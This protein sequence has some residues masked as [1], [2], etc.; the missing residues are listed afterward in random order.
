MISQN[1]EHL[2][3]LIGAPRSGTTL[4]SVILTR[5][6]ELHCPPELWLGLPATE[7][8]RAV[9]QLARLDSD[10]ELGQRALAEAFEERE[11]REMVASFLVD[12]Y[13]RILGRAGSAKMLI[14]K[15]PRYYK[16]GSLLAELLPAAR[17][18]LLARNPLDVAASQKL[19]WKVDLARLARPA[20]I[21]APSFDLFCAP[22][23]MV[24][25]RQELGQRAHWLHYEALV[26]RPAEVMSGVCGFL[27]VP[28]R[29]ELL[30]YAADAEEVEAHRSSS[31]GDREIW[32]HRAING[33]AAGRWRDLL[34]EREARLV[35]GLVGAETFEA[36]GY[37][38]PYPE[39]NRVEER[40]FLRDALLADLT[41]VG[42][43]AGRGSGKAEVA[44][45]RAKLARAVQE[46]EAERQARARWQRQ[47]EQ[48]ES[49]REHARGALAEEAAE[50]E[51][52]RQVGRQAESQRDQFGVELKAELIAKEHWQRVSAAER[53]ARVRERE[54]REAESAEKEHWRQLCSGAELQIELERAAR[55]AEL[56]EKERWQRQ[57]AEAEIQRDAERA[58]REEEAAARERWQRQCSEAEI[59]RDAERA[60]REE[61][62]AARERWQRQCSEAEIQRDAERAAREEEAA[63]KEHWSTI[64]RAAEAQRD[65]YQ[66]DLERLEMLWPWLDPDWVDSAEL[67]RISIVTPS[68]NQ[69]EWIE[70][71]LQSVLH[72]R[73]PNFEHIVV[74]GGS[75]DGT[76]EIVARYPHIRF[77][78]EPDLGQAH[79]INKGILVATGDIVAYLNSDDLYRTGAFET[80][81]KAFTSDPQLMALAGGCDYVDEA[82]ATIG[83]MDARLDRY[84]D[85]LRYWGWESWF[86]LPQQ[87][88][89]WR[90]DLL[91][92]VGLFDV[93]FQFTMD[94]EMWLR[95]AARHPFRIEE[96]T[97]AAFRMQAESK[98]ISRTHLMYLEER[99]AARR[100]WP[101]WWRSSRW[102]LEVT[103]LRH[104]GRK[105]LDVAEHEAL[106]NRHRRHPL[107]LLRLGAAHW[108]L[109][110][111][112]PRWLLTLASAVTAKS[113]IGRLTAR[114]HRGYLHGLWRLHRL[115]G[116]AQ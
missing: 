20:G 67:P 28:Y 99:R 24:E 90:R 38:S 58:T 94:Y 103:S 39:E 61:E 29:A 22:Q 65:R 78:E 72:Q 34:T 17:F 54:V 5:A 77:I 25:L 113:R 107:K 9:P 76:R 108:P 89:F 8:L 73:Y 49:Q 44:S 33:Q 95:V 104:T 81:A 74:D 53:E 71:T 84:W 59:Q 64:C 75:T 111:F 37:E 35:C 56:T 13:N 50:K 51:K 2:A 105:M 96:S 60:T 36:L 42:S 48:A 92:E 16:I 30:D 97:L 70:A 116:E 79:A 21:A 82:G 32:K 80:V 43:P 106:A 6:R 12:A 55:E 11:L 41:G 7:L 114:V 112:S 101:A 68:F 46:T 31:F 10:H 4:V 88:V 100:Y 102:Y 47:Y 115:R 98:T 93:G 57:C 62:A 14:D 109:V 86:C 66:R 87:A 1:G 91:S 40:A 18:V 23:R 83:H 26:E 110:L 63:A 15:T 3:F 69:A 45:L 85:L 19:R 52:W 27:G